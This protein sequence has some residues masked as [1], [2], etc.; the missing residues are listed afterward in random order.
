MSSA[1]LL[2]IGA[3]RGFCLAFG[4]HVQIARGQTRIADVD[5][6]RLHADPQ[7]DS[8]HQRVISGSICKWKGP[9]SMMS[10]AASASFSSTGLPLRMTDSLAVTREVIIV[11]NLLDSRLRA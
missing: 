2:A 4:G 9:T 3:A 7:L 1:L 6:G 11:F 8:Y 10:P 5:L